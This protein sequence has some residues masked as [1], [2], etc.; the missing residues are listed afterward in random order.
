MRILCVVLIAFST[1]GIGA[2]ESI[3]N[4]NFTAPEGE[5]L[6]GLRICVDAGHGGQIWGATRGYTGGTRSVV[7]STTESEANLRVAMFLWDLLT[8]A[9]ADVVMTRTFETRLSE[10]SFASRRSISPNPLWKEV[11]A[12]CWSP[13]ETLKSWRSQPNTE[14]GSQP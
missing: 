2:Q 4:P 13:I 3:Q 12:I 10:D 9:G 6:A 7:S 1:L 8:Q 11:P 5:P 14:M